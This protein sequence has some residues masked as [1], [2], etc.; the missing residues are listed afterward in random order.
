MYGAGLNG[1]DAGQSITRAIGRGQGVGHENRDFL[2][3]EMA[4]SAASAIWARKSPVLALVMD[5]PSTQSLS[6]SSI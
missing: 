6:S 4:S 5:L 3:P 2:D 1:F